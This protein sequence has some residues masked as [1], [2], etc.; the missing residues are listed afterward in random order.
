MPGELFLLAFDH[1]RSL[2]SSFFGVRG[3]PTSEDAARATRLKLVVWEGLERALAGGVPPASAGVLV[4]ATYGGDV[5]DRAR[6]AG[7]RVAAPLEASGRDEFAFEVDAWRDRLDE[8][9]PAWAKV[10]VRYNPSGDAATNERQRQ[11]LRAV[12]EH[13][14]ASG[15]GFMFELLVPA[16]PNQLRAVGN[17]AGR[18]D[19]EVRPGLTVRAIEELHASGVEP[20]VWKLEGLE[21]PEHWGEVAAA[22]C[23]G[24]PAPRRHH[25]GCVVLGRGADLE[26]VERW[27]RAA[28]RIPAFVG[29]AVGRT[30]WWDPMRSFFDAGETP[31]A[32]NRAT[33]EIARR[34]RRLVESFT[35]ARTS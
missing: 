4:D 10:L 7:V 31:E 18:F 9:D 25:V 30:I 21:R 28:A 5:I 27:L 2:L 32:R 6:R 22:A 15:R 24:G 3:E 29:F 13:C 8:L 16:E 23:G 35:G 33:G 19:H 11:A 1:R 17:D 34:Y 12:S 26:T 14:R 20:D